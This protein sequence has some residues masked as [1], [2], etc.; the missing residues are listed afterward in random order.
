MSS[1]S[2]QPYRPR[3]DRSSP[4]AEIRENFHCFRAWEGGLYIHVSTLRV[5]GLMPH[6]AP[7]VGAHS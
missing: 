7:I 5:V 1:S 3:F 2:T 4:L 6:F